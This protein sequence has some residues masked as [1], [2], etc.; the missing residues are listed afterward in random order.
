MLIHSTMVPL[1]LPRAGVGVGVVPTNLHSLHT[2]HLWSGI[3]SLGAWFSLY[4]F[5]QL[6]RTA[7]A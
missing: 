4:Q 1:I 3:M 6:V 2:V 7:F 5:S